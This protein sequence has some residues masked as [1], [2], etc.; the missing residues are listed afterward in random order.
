MTP[1]VAQQFRWYGRLATALRCVGGY[2]LASIA[3]GVVQVS[4][5]LPP[6][7][8]ITADTDRQIAAGIW[9][10]LASLHSAIFGAPF[11]LVALLVA[12]WK[13]LVNPIFY[14]AAGF[15]IA[16]LGFLT[17]ISGYGFEQPLSVI[18]Y[19]LA[20]FLTGGM[21][22]G[23]VYWLVSGRHAGKSRRFAGKS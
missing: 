4:F 16:V 13:R 3:C 12:E 23:L 9:M 8:L 5:V 10:L 15:S 1:T 6:L 14:I 17:Q 20:A 7:E 21:S 18:L 22:A 2:L 11:A 19:V